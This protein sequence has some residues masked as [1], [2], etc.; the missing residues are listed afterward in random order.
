MIKVYFDGICSN[1]SRE[2]QYYKTIAPNSVFTWIDIAADPAAMNN[3]QITQATALLYL[4][5][6]DH[7]DT[8]HVGSE[9]FALIWKNLPKW[10]ILGHIVSLPIV[11]Q[12]CKFIYQ[13]FAHY[14]FKN[15]KHCQLASTKLSS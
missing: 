2:I 13:R 10:R 8:I 6:I 15:N 5:A 7:D 1:C 11:K 4:H 12:L 9:A 14:R 3:Y